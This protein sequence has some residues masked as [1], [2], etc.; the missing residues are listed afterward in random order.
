[1]FSVSNKFCSFEL[2]HQRILIKSIMVST[3]NI[4]QHNCFNHW[5]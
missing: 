4:K 2:I 1:M 5:W 3:K